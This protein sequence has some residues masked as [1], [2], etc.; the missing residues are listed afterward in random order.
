MKD[1]LKFKVSCKCFLSL[2]LILL[3][4]ASCKKD[5]E[6]L[7]YD[8]KLITDKQLEQDANAGGFLLPTMELSIISPSEGLYE[9]QIILHCMDFCGYVREPYPDLNNVN[10]STYGMVDSW[11]NG[12]WSVPASGVL[13]NWVAMKK[14][15]YNTKYSDLFAMATIFKVFSGHRLVDVF[16]PIPYSLYGTAS[17]VAFDSGKAAYDLFFTELKAAVDT[18]KRYEGENATADQV[19]YAKFDKS[20]Y[21]GDYAKWIKVANTLRLRL[22]IRIS[23]VDP[24][25]AQTEAE[26]AV[27]DSY[28]VIT[29]SEGSCEV[30]SGNLHP[31]VAITE[32]W[33]D[34]GLNAALESILSGFNDPRLPVYAKPSSLEGDSIKGIRSGAAMDVNASQYLNFSVLNFD[35][36][37]YVKL[38]DVS[39]SYFLR[40]EGALKG[41]NMGGTAKDFYEE[42][43]RLNFTENGLAGIES[44]LN[45]ATSTQK[46]YV[47][48]LNPVNNAAPLSSITVKW[49]ENATTEQKL[50]RIIVQKWIAL[51]PDGGEA[52][53]EFRRTGY[54]KLWP[55]V[56]N[57]SN[58]IV[59]DGQFIKRLAYPTA[60]TNSSSSAVKVAVDTYLNGNDNI[61]QPIW[62][63][64]N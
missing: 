2:F 52:W 55:V 37:Y 49:D 15:G 26:A 63:D 7:N 27:N 43:I 34:T 35:G 16:G 46:S 25:K 59:P 29:S 11:N 30:T 21:A 5:V 33:R 56:V 20:K 12:V 62:W 48:P 38:I 28:G 23:K 45:D 64:V 57:Y 31:L 58:G 9:G 41:W 10:N 17:D 8:Q 14:K 4:S 40:A 36:V 60:I 1:F 50:E 18:L 3:L 47:D 61:Y 32:S 19:R 39:E 53:A 44:Y 24:V 42:G 13:D 22:A 6:N 54:P 51:Y